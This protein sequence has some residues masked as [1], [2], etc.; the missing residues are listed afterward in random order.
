MHCMWR[1]VFRIL[2]VT[3]GL[4]LAASTAWAQDEETAPE[5]R[6]VPY[7]T[8]S[9]RKSVEIANFYLKK[10][11]YR[12]AL[13][14][15]QEAVTTDPSYAPAYLGLGKVYEKIGLKQKAIA[16]Y[17]RYVDSLPSAKQAE[18]A[19]DVQRALERLKAEIGGPSAVPAPHG[20]R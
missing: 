17:Q 20:N 2:L 8:P 12:A 14:R 9:A 1:P 13:S 10:K 19:K 18:E 3:F 7:A 5:P 4:G 15:Y 6:P 11:K 16:A